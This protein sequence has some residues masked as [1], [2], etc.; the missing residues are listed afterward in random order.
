MKPQRSCQELSQLP[1]VHRLVVP[2]HTPSAEPG[3]ISPGL[4]FFST[5]K[6]LDRA[7]ALRPYFHPGW[8]SE[9]GT[10]GA[11]FHQTG[12][13]FSFLSS[14]QRSPEQQRLIKVAEVDQVSL[15]TRIHPCPMNSPPGCQEVHSHQQ[16][17]GRGARH[18][19]EQPHIQAAW[20]LS[21]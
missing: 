10:R 20:Y 21:F 13:P 4:L 15:V 16:M 8:T 7:S 19:G 14:Q 18:P 17:G 9:L 2:H 6:I 3:R 12:K 5:T 1:C 11:F